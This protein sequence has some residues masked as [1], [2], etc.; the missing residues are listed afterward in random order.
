MDNEIVGPTSKFD[1]SRIESLYRAGVLSLAEISRQCGGVK[2]QQINYMARKFDW[3][4]NLTP[5]IMATAESRL[6]AANVKS[7]RPTEG[8]IVSTAADDIVHIVQEH[9]TQI[10]KIRAQIK[11]VL[12]SWEDRDK[13][14]QVSDI[15]VLAEA[16]K[17]LIGLERQAFNMDDKKE[18]NDDDVLSLVIQN[19][20]EVSKEPQPFIIDHEPQ[21]G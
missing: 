1:W 2:P 18:K 7:S 8:Q 15:K 11:R 21:Q 5:R 17:I 14:P 4:R 20:V 6:L 13:P 3:Q 16:E 10:R 12:A 9:R 19:H